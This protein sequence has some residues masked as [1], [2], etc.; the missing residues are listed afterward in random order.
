M[1]HNHIG[2]NHRLTPGH[3]PTVG[4]TR[5]RETTPS[6][7]MSLTIMLELSPKSSKKTTACPSSSPHGHTLPQLRLHGDTKNNERTHQTNPEIQIR[8]L[9]PQPKLGSINASSLPNCMWSSIERH[10]INHVD[11]PPYTNPQAV[12][13]S[14][15]RLPK[16][17]KTQQCL[18][19]LIR[20]VM[21]PF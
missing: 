19:H 18:H 7:T 1:E 12:A 8:K 11:K 4:H 5:Q 10:I 3:M 20:D 9:E 16:G 13:D 14:K 15:E 17:E 21:F 6:L 2:H